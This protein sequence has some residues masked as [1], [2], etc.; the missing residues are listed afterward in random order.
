VVERDNILVAPTTPQARPW[1]DYATLT[2]A[3]DIV[4][5]ASRRAVAARPHPRTPSTAPH[6]EVA[7]RLYLHLVYRGDPRGAVELDQVL[8][9]GADGVHPYLALATQHRVLLVTFSIPCAPVPCSMRRQSQDATS[10]DRGGTPSP[11]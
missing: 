7:Y 9:L 1:T 8:A 2:R 6:A 4:G 11:V 3:D 10:N 5:G